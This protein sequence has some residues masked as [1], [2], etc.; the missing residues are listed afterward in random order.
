MSGP[1]EHVVPRQLVG[2]IRRGSL[3]LV[4]H[5]GEGAIGARPGN[6]LPRGYGDVRNS[7]SGRRCT[8]W[9]APEVEPGRR[10]SQDVRAGQAIPE[11][12]FLLVEGTPRVGSAS[13]R[14]K[15]LVLVEQARFARSARWARFI[16][17]PHLSSA[18]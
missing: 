16:Q 5:G 18:G 13:G 10:F 8:G 12:G 15:I 6:S 4:D 14:T 17:L 2:M 1:S 7:S 3:D 9:A 11:R